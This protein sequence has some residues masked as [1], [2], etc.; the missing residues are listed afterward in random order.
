MKRHILIRWTMGVVI[1]TLAC[2]APVAATM[3]PTPTVTATSLPASTMTPTKIEPTG[4]SITVTP[5]PAQS[6]DS[7]GTDAAPTSAGIDR[8]NMYLIGLEDNGASGDVIGCQDSVIPVERQIAPT[9]APLRAALEELLTIRDQYLGQ[10]GLYN[11][12][13]QSR[14]TVQDVTIDAS[15]KATIYLEGSL[16]SGGTCDDPRI[17][18]QL[19]YTARQFSTVEEAVIYVNGTQIEELLSGK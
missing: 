10:S 3:T 17:I 2:N 5:T 8:V 7:P 14:L 15:G 19:T 13:Y 1:G 16:L 11:A 18:A 4:A 12:L 6:T 9:R